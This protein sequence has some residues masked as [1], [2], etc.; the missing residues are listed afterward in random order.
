MGKDDKKPTVDS[1]AVALSSAKGALLKIGVDLN[2]A[3][4]LA[5][6]AGKTV[7]GKKAADLAAQA[8]KMFSD[9]SDL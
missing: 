8:V 7:E 3:S 4:R 1:Y 6:K 5:M 9:I 2:K